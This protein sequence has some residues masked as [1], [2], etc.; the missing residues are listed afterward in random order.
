MS[1]KRVDDLAAMLLDDFAIE[2]PEII[3]A[4][5]DRFVYEGIPPAEAASQA[6]D[7][8]SLA[9]DDPERFDA[10]FGDTYH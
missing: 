3:A 2:V 10:V 9:M 1:Y 5:A 4:L 6:R 7:M 8:L